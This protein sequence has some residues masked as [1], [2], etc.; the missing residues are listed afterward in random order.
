MRR[1]SKRT[2][3]V[4]KTKRWD[5]IT[6]LLKH[7]KPPRS[8]YLGA[9]VG[10]WKARNSVRL[11]QKNPDLS[12]YVCDNWNPIIGTTY[13]QEPHNPGSNYKMWESVHQVAR[14]RLKQFED[15]V[16]FIRCMSA[17]GASY[18]PDACLHFAFIDANHTYEA[19]KLDIEAWRPK[20]LRGGYMCGHDYKHPNKDWGVEQAVKECFPDH[21]IHEEEDHVWWVKL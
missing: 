9:E 6:R 13:R 14:K 2:V 18:V 17:E 7:I 8:G 19:C 4:R 5:I 11:L 10:V 16:Y 3:R 1:S 21:E 15:R 12:L 20:I